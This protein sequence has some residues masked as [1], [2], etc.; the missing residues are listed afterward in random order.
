VKTLISRLTTP[1]TIIAILFCVKLITPGF[2]DPDFYWHLKTGEYIVSNFSIPKIDPFAYTSSGMHWVAHEWLSEVIFHLVDKSFGFWGLKILVASTFC[3]TFTVL[4][5]FAKKMTRNDTRA[6]ILVLVFFAPLMPYGSPRPQIF[7]F[8]LFTILL[9]ILLNFKYLKSTKYLFA[10]PFLMPLWVNLHGAYAVGFVMLLLFTGLEW[11]KHIFTDNRDLQL[12][13]DL[14]RL[15]VCVLI[16]GLTANINPHFFEIWTYPF[17][18]VSMEVSKGII[19][20]WRSPD[21]H[22]T[23]Y[24]YYLIVIIG[25]LLSLIYLKKKPDITELAFPVFFICAGMVSQRH[26]PLT[27]FVLLFFSA[28]MYRHIAL[29]IEWLTSFGKAKSAIDATTKEIDKSVVGWLNLGLILAVG[30]SVMHMGIGAKQ[31]QS[32]EKDLPVKA[33]DYILKN[34]ITGN[35]LND[36]GYGGYLIYRLAPARK[37]FIDGRADMYGDP[38]VS[39][40]LEIHNGGNN[41]KE[42]FDKFSIDYVITSKGAPIRQILLIEGNFKE[43]FEADGHSVLVR[44]GTTNPG[45]AKAGSNESSLNIK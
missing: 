30:A 29:P 38:F 16:S 27:C 28:A 12:R 4:F 21:F 42:K 15:T 33:V 13:R 17:Y 44:T 22:Q 6:L 10:I 25:F 3:A 7:T 43:V 39:D 20:E 26:L 40:F 32:V 1:W 31:E 45:T 14:W 23:F 36:Y 35:M 19:A 37:V 18:L 9:F 41:W 2:S 11:A 8:L 34:N 5:R 24:K